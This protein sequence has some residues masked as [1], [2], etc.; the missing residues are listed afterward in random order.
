MSDTPVRDTWPKVR[1]RTHLII[2]LDDAVFSHWPLC[3]LWVRLVSNWMPGSYF[4]LGKQPC[5]SLAYQLVRSS[6]LL[7]NEFSSDR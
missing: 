6:L 4:K 2:E 5:H 7:R 1:G 3:N